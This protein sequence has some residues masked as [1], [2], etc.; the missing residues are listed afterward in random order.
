MWII[1]PAREE[2]LPQIIA[3]EKISHPMP[4][5]KE[6]FEGELDGHLPYSYL[7]VAASSDA[8]SK[9]VGYICFRW[10]A[11]E[12]YIIKLTVAPDSRRCGVGAR[13]L[14]LCI[15]WTKLHK[16]TKIVLDVRKDNLSALEFY[17]QAGFVAA[18]EDM[19]I[20]ADST[21]AMVMTLSIGG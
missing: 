21:H 16:G 8:L 3:I 14:E 12:V 11:S 9:V 4:W 15:R 19:D 7:W 17:R 18:R 20:S 6:D 2:Y 10:L 5:S 13:L 1:R